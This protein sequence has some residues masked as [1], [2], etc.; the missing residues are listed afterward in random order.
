M[1]SHDPTPM[2]PSE[3]ENA[4]PSGSA[5]SAGAASSAGLVRSGAVR[6]WALGAG[7][8]AALLSWLLIEATLNSFKPK[9]TATRFMTS[10]YMIP[11][12]AERATA[13][14]RN[15]VLAL[16]LM[17]ATVGLTFGLSGG[18]ARRVRPEPARLRRSW[19]WC[20]AR[21]R[22]QELPRLQ[23]HSRLV[24]TIE[25]PEACRSRWPRRCSCTAFRGRLSAQSA[26]W[27]S[28]SGWGDASGRHVASWVAFWVPS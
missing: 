7:V 17:G 11:G 19:D 26:G 6:V 24:F 9:G 8:A 12:A 15:A 1:E 5:L 4:N 21:L 27:L 22:E 14:T 23:C 18:L 16:G 13:E 3:G 20:W 25:I 28:A 10:T 2:S